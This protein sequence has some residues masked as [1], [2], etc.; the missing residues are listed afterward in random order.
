[1][2]KNGLEYLSAMI[3]KLESWMLEKKYRSIDEFR[4]SM[5]YSN[6]PDPAV[7][8]RAQFMKYFSNLT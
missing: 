6:I 3:D 7:Y 5:N 1:L 2:Y 4:G 8:E